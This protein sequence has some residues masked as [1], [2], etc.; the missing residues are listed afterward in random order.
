MSAV[1]AQG[2]LSCLKKHIP[3][4]LSKVGVAFLRTLFCLDVPRKLGITEGSGTF[5]T[6]DLRLCMVRQLC[7]EEES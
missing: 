1:R 5:K 7:R 4:K 6:T 2:R 3:E